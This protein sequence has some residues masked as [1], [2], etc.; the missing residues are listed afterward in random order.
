MIAD[1]LRFETLLYLIVSLIL[2]SIAKSLY[3]SI[4][5]NRGKDAR[6]CGDIKKYRHYDPIFGLDYV[7]AMVTALKEHRFL[8]FQKQ[9]FAAQGVKTFE[10]KFFGMRMVYSS[11]VENMK[12]M[13]TSMWKDFG[14][15]PIRNGNGAATP[16]IGHGTSTSDGE[17]WEYSRGLIKPYF[18]RGGYHN[19][20][21]LAVHTDRLLDNVPMD[22]STFDLQPLLQRWFL[23]TSTEF[24]YGQ[25]VNSLTYPDHA[26]PAWAMVDVMR[27]I[28]LRL[29]MNRMLFLYRDKTWFDAVA[30]VHKFVDAQIDKTFS[31]L[32]EREL[33]RKNRKK[34]SSPERTDLLWV[35]AQ[36]LRD[37]KALRS[38]ILAV[39]VP[40]ND[41]TSI[42]ISNAFYAL[43]RHP[44][45]W[46]KLREEVASVDPEN[47]TWD[48]LRGMR[49]LNWILNETHRLYPNGIQ[50]VRIAL[51]DTTL[52]VGGG[53]TG[54][55]P[56]YLRKG[57][58]M[59]CNRYLMHR[60]PDTWGPDAEEFIPERW[61]DI[62]P[63][64]RFV[65][66]G[67]GP[68]ICPAHVLVTTEASY[69]LTRFAQKFKTIEARDQRE[70]AVMP[71]EKA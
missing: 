43:A 52:P 20:G 42:L 64:W 44:K 38:Q 21:R 1:V 32:D 28:R 62:R 53:P 36:Q 48:T 58:V 47:L 31:E 7:Y 56:I 65:P 70:I 49:Y 23:D 34:P 30:K 10:A 60:D 46:A 5:Y 51:R 6:G 11:E 8:P 39:F 24:L 22:S 50:M 41:T 18:D 63:M 59:H 29:Q 57:D 55:L 37:K 3:K 67:G 25:T 16:F 66:F 35:M 68:R 45:V 69:V 13:S 40:S 33:A 71:D 12:A 61:E 26:E 14:V 9:L 17:I 27:G 15:T 19:L 54:K 2:Y 4:Q